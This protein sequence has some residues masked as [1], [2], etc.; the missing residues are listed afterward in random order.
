M[1][2]DNPVQIRDAILPGDLE[3]VERLW[4]DYLIWGNETMQA[5]HGIHPHH[6]AQ[7]VARDIAAI[8][9]FQPPT[10]RLLLSVH[11]GRVC[12][13]GGLHR[14]DDG[15]AEIK[16]MYVEPTVRGV[17]AGRALL[18]G[19]VAAAAEAGYHRVRLDSLDIMTTAHALYRRCGFVDIPAYPESEI[20]ER[21]RP[22]MVFMERDLRG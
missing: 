8:A 6:P 15:I 1:A 7:A 3:T 11:D 14:I 17:G 12:G 22:H 5:R 16:R 20:A 10:G 9:R 19:L 2:K 21:F 18:E 13:I 4:L